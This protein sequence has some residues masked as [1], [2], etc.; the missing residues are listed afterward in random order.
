MPGCPDAARPARRPS[1]LTIGLMRDET[2]ILE[3]I[4]RALDGL[5]DRTAKL[6][7]VASILREGG[8]YRWVGIY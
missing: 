1:S 5:D 2:A 7:R 8:G 6:R 3:D 4:R